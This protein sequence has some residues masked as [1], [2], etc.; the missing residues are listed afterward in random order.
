MKS[1]SE[2]GKKKDHGHK[3]KEEEFKSL[4]TESSECQP[5][6]IVTIRILKSE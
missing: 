1:V 2:E 6:L 5:E 4:M 3:V